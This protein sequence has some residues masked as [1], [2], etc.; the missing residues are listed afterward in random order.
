MLALSR[1]RQRWLDLG[2]PAEHFR[3]LHGG[4]AQRVAVCTKQGGEWS[5]NVYAH[6]DAGSLAVQFAGS[7][8]L[9]VYQSQNGFHKR[10]TIADV[11]AITSSYLDL[12]FYKVPGLAG[13]SVEEIL[14]RV[15]DAH[16]WLPAPTFIVSSGRGGY[17]SW[18]YPQP[19]GGELLP[20]WKAVEDILCQ[21]LA[22]FGADPQARDAARVLRVIGSVNQK[23]GERVTGSRD[24]GGAIA[25]DHL[26]RLVTTYGLAELRKRAQ[27][28]SSAAGLVVASTADVERAVRD[29]GKA[30]AA[31]RAQHL[32][33]LQLA[34][35]RM[36]D[37]RVIARLR[38]VPLTDYRARLLFV[39][40]ASAVWYATAEDQLEAELVAFADDHFADGKRYGLRQVGTVIDRL[41]LDQEGLPRIWDGARIPNRYRLSN[42]WII[43]SLEI[44]GA[45]QRELR[46]VISAQERQRRRVE[47][48]R[49]AGMVTREDYQAAA[50]DRRTRAV[51][52]RQ[53]G[54]T[55][56]AIAAELGITQGHVSKLLRAAKP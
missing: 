47:R 22:P 33:P 40:A 4:H 1:N 6:D 10:R 31:Q 26:Y 51:A 52:L 54:L 34:H 15:L 56:T 21:L 8:D 29:S 19:L 45:E 43:D 9:N 2:D 13:L 41:R 28:Q 20:K 24:T 18:L 49:K 38:G 35:D 12:D 3:L 25:F 16:P 53:R 14:D 39:F 48:R 44:T 50:Q 17:F 23:S 37:C 30:T 55:Q 46:T 27:A 5:E 32:L 36:A 42:P 7:F 11:A